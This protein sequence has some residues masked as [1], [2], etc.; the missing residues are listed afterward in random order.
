MKAVVDSYIPYIR[1]PL[2][3]LVDEVTYVPGSAITPRDVRDAD[4]LIVRTRTLCNRSLLSGSKVRLVLTATD[5]FDH[6]DTVYLDY[7]GIRWANCPGCNS[8]SVAQYVRNSLLLWGRDRGKSLSQLTVGIIGVGHVGKAVCEALVPFGCRL[9]LHDPP[10]QEREGAE[11][12][13]SMAELQRECDVITIHTPLLEGGE[14]PTFHLFDDALLRSFARKPLIINTSR[15]EVVDNVALLR[16][17]DEGFVGQAIIDTW[18]NE[19]HPLPQLLER[20]FIGTPHIAGYSADGRAN[21]ARM[22]LESLCHWMDR[23]MTFQIEPPYLP[24]MKM[25]Q[26]PAD[27]ALA[28][29]NPMNDSLQ[30]KANPELFEHLRE[31]YPLR[32]EHA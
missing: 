25:P 5:G 16:A 26:E 8:T 4:V 29:Y 7:A 6:L 19:P 11:G 28:L 2:E 30:L 12:F 24:E 1:E 17:I 10:R 14:H 20:V 32:R 18:E 27:R 13:S 31:S 22:T 23:E 15:G 21:A 3:S 9:L